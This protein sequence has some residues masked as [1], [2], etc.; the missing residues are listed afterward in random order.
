[1]RDLRVAS[2]QME[3]AAGDKEANFRK[4][5]RFAEQAAAAGARIVVTPE[6]G[7]TGY[8]FLRRLAVPQ[9]AALAERVPDGPSCERLIAL[10]KRFGV[11]VGAGLVEAAGELAFHNTYVVAMPDGRLVR[12]RK[13]HAF[14][15]EWAVEAAFDFHRSIGRDKV[16]RRV[17]ALNR[18]MKEQL[19]ALPHVTV[20]T[21]MSDT[22]SAGIVGFDVRGLK[23]A[24][25]VER[26]RRQRIIASESPYGRSMVR[27]SAGIMNS[28]EDIDV[29]VRAVDGLRS[30][31][32]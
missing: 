1:M 6:C 9:L 26:L 18:R 10:S 15:H 17:H 32:A 2:V 12:H 21:P 13:L 31:G 3:S 24:D 20:Y 29:A 27:L 28:P 14:E 16:A 8:W 19:A 11:T 4:V 23:P 5:E 30:E 7:L 25:V 22:L